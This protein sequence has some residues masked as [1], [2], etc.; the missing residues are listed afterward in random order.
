MIKSNLTNS[1][2]YV[3]NEDFMKLQYPKWLL[4][5]ETGTASPACRLK[6]DWSYSNKR[7]GC[8]RSCRGDRWY[9]FHSGKCLE[10]WQSCHGVCRAGMSP[11]TEG[12][13]VKCRRE[14]KKVLYCTA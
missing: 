9:C 7:G 2:F 12:K 14:C 13:A 6:E 11:C 4:C 10:P 3:A 1:C 8:V 5:P